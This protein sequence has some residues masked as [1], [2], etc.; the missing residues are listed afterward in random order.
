[1]KLYRFLSEDDTDAFCHKISAALNKGWALHGGPT[2]AYDAGRGVMRCGQAV[3]KDA[4]GSYS[5][6]VKLWD[7]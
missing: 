3:V 6:D 4:P 2:Y 5:A 7:H 1:M